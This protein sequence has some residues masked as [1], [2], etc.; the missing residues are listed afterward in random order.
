VAVE[1]GHRC[2]KARLGTVL[3]DVGPQGSGQSRT[4]LAAPKGEQSNKTLTARWHLNRLVVAVE[5][6]VVEQ[7]ELQCSGVA[8]LGNSPLGAPVWLE[9]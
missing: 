3:V 1:R 6:P 5:M 2:A 8:H 9:N 7:P 4:T